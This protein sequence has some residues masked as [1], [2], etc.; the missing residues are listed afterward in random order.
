[1]KRVPVGFG[2]DGHRLNAQLLAGADHPQ[3]DFT[4]IG[5]Q[6]LPEHGNPK[7]EIGNWKIETGKWKLETRKCKMINGKLQSFLGA[8]LRFQ[9][10]LLKT[11]RSS[12]QKMHYLRFLVS[13]FPFS[14]F[15]FP[16]SNF[17]FRL[18]IF[19]FPVISSARA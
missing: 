5:N 7:L 4:A 9:E 15:Y 16:V 11:L 12:G 19:Q 8:T 2:I 3:G 13:G 10:P 18:S 1:V 6:D 17:D 14:S